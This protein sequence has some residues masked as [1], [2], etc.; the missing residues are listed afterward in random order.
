MSNK[1][2]ENP[3][4]PTPKIIEPKENITLGITTLSPTN[5]NPPKTK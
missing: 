2:N 3:K 4:P 5:M 1:N